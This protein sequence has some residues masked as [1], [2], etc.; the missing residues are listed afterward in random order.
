MEPIIYKPSIYKGAGI[1]KTGA[2]GGG[3][4]GGGGFLPDGYKKVSYIQTDGT[5]NCVIELDNTITCGQRQVNLNFMLGPSLS[6]GLKSVLRIDDEK[7]FVNKFCYEVDIGDWSKVRPTLQVTANDMVIVNYSGGSYISFADKE[8]VCINEKN[9]Q[10]SFIT[11]FDTNSARYIRK[12]IKKISLFES[13]NSGTKLLDSFILDADTNKVVFTLL[14]CQ[15]VD[16]SLYGFFDVV[17]QQFY[18]ATT[19]SFTG[20]L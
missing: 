4:G 19:G 1:Y 20:G 13:V 2:E 11:N 15:E 6:N 5:A 3:G 16:T 14:P 18:S 12:N 10:N 7:G 8:K 17:G 9:T